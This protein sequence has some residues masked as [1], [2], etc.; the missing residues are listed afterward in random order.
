MHFNFV[1][2]FRSKL[3]TWK[4]L[5]GFK[6]YG[7]QKNVSKLLRIHFFILFIIYIY[8]YIYIHTIIVH[9][10]QTN[11]CSILYGWAGL[12]LKSGPKETCIG[13]ATAHL[14]LNCQCQ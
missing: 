10:I 1:V 4:I 2:Y 14:H 5:F 11:F 9:P 7:Q 8:T 13:S 3:D 12:G 6:S